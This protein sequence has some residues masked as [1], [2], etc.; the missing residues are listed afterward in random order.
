LAAVC[1]KSCDGVE[2]RRVYSSESFESRAL[3]QSFDWFDNLWGGQLFNYKNT[4]FYQLYRLIQT[5]KTTIMNQENSAKQDDKD[6]EKPIIVLVNRKDVTFNVKKTTGAEIKST[7]I[8]QGVNIKQDFALFEKAGAGHGEHWKPV[9]DAEIVTLHP[10]QEFRAV[11][12][13]DNSMA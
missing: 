4:K 3:D 5:I 11:A 8:S 13:D 10:N 6:K 12:P 1:Q 7:A 2:F 9:G